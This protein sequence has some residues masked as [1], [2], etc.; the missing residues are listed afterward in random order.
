MQRKL[1]SRDIEEENEE[2]VD[3]D[4]LGSAPFEAVP[5]MA[6]QMVKNLSSEDEGMREMATVSIANL[7][8]EMDAQFYQQ[9]LAKP[10]LSKLTETITDAHSQVCYNS[11]TAIQR[12]VSLSRIHKQ[13]GL[14]EAGF[15]ETGLVGNVVSQMSP[16]VTKVKDNVSEILSKKETLRRTC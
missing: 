15:L 1:F 12:L 3:F 13:P 10:V 6:S 14:L 2:I 9:F 8:S 4:M 7:S 11:L 5:D 16:V